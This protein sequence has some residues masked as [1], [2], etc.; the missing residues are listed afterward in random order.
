MSNESLSTSSAIDKDGNG[1]VDDSSDYKLAGPGGGV[2]LQDWKGRRYSDR[3][4]PRW[5][6]V[7]A[8]ESGKNYQILLEGEGRKTGKYRLLAVNAAGRINS[9][10]RW[11]STA[12]ALEKGWEKLFGDVIRVDGVKGPVTDANGDGFLDGGKGYRIV[13]DTDVVGLQSTSGGL[14]SSKSSK[15]WDAIKAIAVDDGFQVLVQTEGKKKKRFRVFDVNLDGVINDKTKWLKGAKALFA[16]WDPRFRE[17]LLQQNSSG[18]GIQAASVDEDTAGQ[19]IYTAI[20]TDES[21]VTYGL[22]APDDGSL[23][24]LSINASTGEVHLNTDAMTTLPEGVAFIVKATDAAGNS[25]ELAVDVTLSLTVID[26]AEKEAPAVGETAISALSLDQSPTDRPEISSLAEEDGDTK[27]GLGESTPTTEIGDELITQELDEQEESTEI[28]E[29]EAEAEPQATE[30]NA[31]PEDLAQPDDIAEPDENVEPDENAEPKQVSPAPSLSQESDSGHADQDRVTNVV[32]PEFTGNAPSESR[33]QLSANGVLLGETTADQQG[34]WRFTVPEQLA[35][36]DGQ[37]AITAQVLDATG[38]VLATSDQLDVVVDGTEPQF[39]SESEVSATVTLTSNEVLQSA[40]VYYVSNDGDD[41]ASGTKAR[42]F[43]TIQHAINLARPGNII[44]IRG[45]TY[46]ERLRFNDVHGALDAPITITN[47]QDEDVILTGAE[48][49]SSSWVVHEGNIWKTKVDFDVSQ[50]FLDGSMLTAARWPNIIKEWDRIDTSDRRDATPNSYWDMKTRALAVVDPDQPDLYTNQEEHQ[51]LSNLGLSLVGAMVVPHKSFG[52]THSGEIT[53]HIAGEESFDI[54]QNFELS[55]RSDSQ[56]PLRNF[57][58]TSANDGNIEFV[59]IWPTKNGPTPGTKQFHYHLEGHLGLLDSPNEWHYDKET[60]ELYVWLPEQRDPNISILQARSWDPKTSYISDPNEQPNADYHS[61]LEMDESSFID[62]KGI[63]LHTG[64]FNLNEST[65]INFDN[66]RFLYPTY[67]GRMLKDGRR[68]TYSN[69]IKPVSLKGRPELKEVPDSNII[70]T[71]SEF[72]NDISSLLRA[73]APGLQLINNHIHNVRDRGALRVSSARGMLVERNSFHTF[74]FGGAGKIGDSSH[75]SYNHIHA[76]HGDGDISGI[77]VPASAQEGSII[78]HN[79]IHDAPGRNGIRFDGSPAGIRGLAH[80]NVSTRTRRGMRIKGDQHRIMNNSLISNF[81]YDL[82]ADQG[83]F[84]GYTEEGCLDWQCRYRPQIHGKD[85]DRRLG[86]VNSLILNNAFDRMPE[87]FGVRSP[88]QKVGNS[89]VSISGKYQDLRSTLMKEELRDPE[90]FDFR[91]NQN[92]SLIDFG[93]H[94]PGITDGFEGIAPDS[95]AY[96]YG[97]DHYWIPGHQTKKARIPIAPDGSN[98]V[99][100]DADLMWLEG[101]DVKA[102]HIYFGTDPEQLSLVSTQTTN[103]YTPED[104]L[105]PGTNYYWRVDTE[106]AEG[107]LHE[108]DLWTFQVAK[109]PAVMPTVLVRSKTETNP[110]TET[111][112]ESSLP[113]YDFFIGKY[114]VTN[115][116]YAQFLN[117][118]ASVD[119][120]DLYN[121]HMAD[122]NIDKGLGGIVRNGTSGDYTYSVVPELAD[123][124]VT[125]VSFWD[126]ARYVN[127]LSTGSTEQGVYTMKPNQKDNKNL[128]IERNQDVFEEG[129][130]AIPTHA[131]WVKAALYRDN[132]D[133][134]LFTFP[135]QSDLLLPDQANILGSTFNGLAPVGIYNQ[136]SPH[137]TYDQAGNAWEWL[138]DAVRLPNG[139]PGR[140][141]K[142]GSFEHIVNKRAMGVSIPGTA[143]VPTEQAHDW[144]FRVVR[145]RTANQQPAWKSTS[146]ELEPAYVLEP[147]SAS[148]ANLAFDSD[149]DPLSFSIEDGPVWLSINADGSLEGVPSEA[150]LGLHSIVFRVEDSKGAFET[151]QTPYTIKVIPDT[152][153]PSVPDAPQLVTESDSGLNN[154]DQLTNIAQP[155]FYGMAE[156]GSTVEVFL[157]DDLLAREKVNE[158]GEWRL[159]PKDS[160]PEGSHQL[161]VR[162]V[163]RADNTSSLSESLKFILDTT[164]PIFRSTN[165]A[166]NL[167]ENS[168]ENQVVYTAD[169]QDSSSVTYDIDDL[170]NF[171]IEPETGVVHFIPNPD[172][173]ESKSYSFTILAIDEAGNIAEQR[174]ELSISDIDDQAPNFISGGKASRL[175]EHSGSGQIVYTARATDESDLVYRLENATENDSDKFSI[176]PSSGEV[177]LLEDPD[178]E[179]IS[180]YRFA[181]SAVDKNNNVATR[182]VQLGIKD[183]DESQVIIEPTLDDSSQEQEDQITGNIY[184]LEAR[185]NYKTNNADLI[186]N[187]DV[188]TDSLE[189]KVSGFGISSSATFD[190]ASNKK[191]FNQLRRSD[192]DFIYR[193][194]NRSSKPGML[195]FNQNGP[196]RGLGKGGGVLAILENTPALDASLVDFI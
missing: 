75:W 189:I 132:P 4:T 8:V 36:G 38:T 41:K 55:L 94:V 6:P 46:R 50:L 92:S 165:Q 145:K 77:Q 79:W 173:E 25:S 127:W 9:K 105:Q 93:K 108:G 164:K 150:D 143:K 99:R 153:P 177:T 181:V 107:P 124:P 123:Y 26:E 30:E 122:T 171:T 11:T 114:E 136:P 140:Y 190:I 119:D 144:G 73:A 191:H 158:A 27:E 1:F 142:G 96:E 51:S 176:D 54:D 154:A 116:Q 195:Y 62:F 40:G 156:M 160:L 48:P 192:V 15:R 170:S 71:N 89:Y 84:Y 81:A 179:K 39:T 60:N 87:G 29:E 126:A 32:T 42:P 97:S 78:S 121:T 72:A 125:Y 3:S 47:Y 169:T 175:N 52:P 120:Y 102:N 7:K 163:D 2:L 167:V 21:A 166:D 104:P 44:T 66:M 31:L 82:S 76:F 184:L 113:D 98:S 43:R 182:K 88:E 65:N 45:G 148:I 74:G 100:P 185:K 134:G 83:K 70:F 178:Y 91:P 63:T 10:T 193:L 59:D 117:S 130:Y 37:H 111:L 118:V 146:W 133:P 131:E 33:I 86:H 14:L 106:T 68:P 159:Q 28:E 139:L 34:T 16:G 5:N 186:T 137:G 162:T 69:L 64:I 135:T 174:V 157:D 196:G 180:S 128:T 187:F 101:L 22:E 95:G 110:A 149:G 56:N 57:N 19:L 17:V 12:K 13:T 161:T 20:A 61:L 80:H 24:G 194:S 53:K 151:I 155:E 183:I 85:K 103:I 90:N 18:G 172:F 112:P 129:G 147:Y 115:A 141:R 138:D 67:D 49:I 168:G 109:A 188:L 23:N 35:L 152:N 58:W